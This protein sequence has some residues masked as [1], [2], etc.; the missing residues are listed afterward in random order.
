MQRRVAPPA[1]QHRLALLKPIAQ[2]L[3]CVF[4]GVARASEGEVQAALAFEGFEL[5]IGGQG[6]PNLF[7]QRLAERRAVVGQVVDVQAEIEGAV[8]GQ[9]AGQAQF[10]QPFE[11]KRWF[12][13]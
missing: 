9:K 6:D 10:L 4:Y 11:Q 1:R 5:R 12:S 3:Q 8:A 7:Q 13:A 2:P